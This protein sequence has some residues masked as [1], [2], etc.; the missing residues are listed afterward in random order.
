MTRSAKKGPFVDERIIKK[1]QKLPPHSKEIVR[2]WSRASEISPEMV[3]Y[4]LGVHNGR[5][6]VAVRITEAMVGYRLGEF[7]PTR[8][9]TRHGGR[10]QKELEG[11]ASQT[12]SRVGLQEPRKE[13]KK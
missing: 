10:M 12:P 5:D 8:K 9:F 3:G 1:L 13:S 6:F 4:T 2:T 11:K 7:S